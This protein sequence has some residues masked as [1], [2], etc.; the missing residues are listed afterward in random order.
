MVSPDYSV[1]DGH[2]N[3]RIPRELAPYEVEVIK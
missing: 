1:E 3:A 2:Y